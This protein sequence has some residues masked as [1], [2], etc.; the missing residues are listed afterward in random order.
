MELLSRGA[1]LTVRQRN[2]ALASLMLSTAIGL[3]GQFLISPILVFELNAR[4]LTASQIGL[5][6][7]TSWMGI[8]VTTPFAAGLASRLG[9]RPVLILSIVIPVVGLTG[10]LLSHSVALWLVLY[11]FVG[12]GSAL[13]WVVAE[14]LITSLAPAAWR[15]RIVGTFQMMLGAAFVTAPSLLAWLGPTNRLA[16]Y[17]SIGLLVAGLLLTLPMPRIDRGTSVGSVTGI[18]DLPSLVLRNPLVLAA[19]FAGGFFE[20]GISSV[21]PVLGLAIGFT[22]AMAALLIA[23]SGMGSALAMLPAGMAADRYGAHGPLHLCTLAL[24]V[25]S[26]LMLMVGHVPGLAWLI[27]LLWGGA[28]GALYTLTMVNIGSQ[29]HGHQLIGVTSVLVLSYTLGGLVGP[30]AFGLAIDWSVQWAPAAVCLA[31]SSV[32]VLAIR[33]QFV[34]GAR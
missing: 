30:V 15:G 34:A 26:L 11:F 20:L 21:L 33:R 25:G 2:L 22:A 1:A 13:R 7:A 28:G 9:M 23:A 24:V 14:A 12:F 3:T 16:S 32:C 17:V 6:S 18:R 29:Y 4:G 8:L 31:V 5:F 27:A 10:I 19:G